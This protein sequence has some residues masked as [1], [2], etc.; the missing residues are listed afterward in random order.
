MAAPVKFADF[1]SLVGDTLATRQ[2]AVLSD[3]SL[4][5][6]AYDVTNAS[7]KIYHTSDRVTFTLVVTI[8]GIASSVFSIA[9]ESG[10]HFQVVY[11]TAAYTNL[12]W[13]RYTKGVGYTWTASAAETAMTHAA[14]DVVMSA[15]LDVMVNA[16]SC[17][18]C[19]RADIGGAPGYQFV[20]AKGRGSNGTWGA[21]VYVTSH[22]GVVG[23]G[24]DTAF[25]SAD[26]GGASGGAQRVLHGA[27]HFTESATQLY[28]AVGSWNVTTGAFVSGTYYYNPYVWTGITNANAHRALSF[29]RTANNWYLCS[30][31]QP[32]G[33]NIT[34]SVVQITWNGSGL[35]VYKPPTT[36]AP[37]GSS[38]YYRPSMVVLSDSKVVFFT[39][40]TTGG[41][42]ATVLDMTTWTWSPSF[43][44]SNTAVVMEYIYAGAQLNVGAKADVV[45]HD[46]SSG[47]FYAD[48]NQTPVAP[49]EATV[50]PAS[51]ATV[52]TDLPTVGV[53]LPAQQAVGFAKRATW[54][55]AND[56]GF[57]TNVKTITEPLSDV[58]TIDGHTE[59][60]TAANELNQGTKYIRAATL[61]PFGQQSAW[62]ASHSFTV[63]HPPAADNLVPNNSEGLDYGLAGE[64]SLDWTFSDTS[65]TD[66]Q[67][68]FQV[69]VENN[70]TGAGVVDSGKVV[71]GDSETI[72]TVPLVSKDVLLRWK[73]RLWDSDDVAGDYSDYATFV[74]GD[75]P[76][77]V[78]TTPAEAG[79]VN[80][81]T[82][83]IEWTFNASAGRVQ[84]QYRVR[85]YENTPQEV[86]VYSSG[87][88]MGA[89]VSHQVPSPVLINTGSYAVEVTVQDSWELQNEDTNLFTT[90][91]VPPA[92]PEFDVN[93]ITYETDG[94][95]SVTWTDDEEDPDF[96]AYR[97][98]RRLS[99]EASWTLLFETTDGGNATYDYHDWTAKSDMEYEFAVVQVANRFGVAV[100]SEYEPETATPISYDYW[101]IH[102][103]DESL[104]IKLDNVTEESF[105]EE[106]EEET[107]QL[108]GRGRRREYGTRWGFSG[109]LSAQVWDTPNRTA[110]EARL[111]LE[112]LKAERREV[113]LRNPFGD[114][115]LVAMG[116]AQ[117]GRM[118]GVGRREFHTLGLSYVEVS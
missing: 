60:L 27:A 62:S 45:M 112:T 49:L 24:H 66:I 57:T 108:I 1:A 2:T 15:D 104:N 59:T 83:L 102:P 18:I 67:T 48:Y 77:V 3:G 23:T 51:G 30:A 93:I 115:W 38:T 96:V 92:V 107:L 53:T 76:T 25:V 56:S 14:G 110:R 100:E 97:V 34:L 75:K 8:T 46:S 13:R 28:S 44:F 42:Y 39:R 117:I 21:E 32:S 12:I 95:V 69:I 74:V 31:Y 90:L 9:V 118:A 40:R 19:W 29:R 16:G 63:L 5:V 17:V 41:V 20:L 109:S 72:V 35:T 86:E 4:L 94:Y 47:D 81:P 103:T 73:V 111:E 84:T 80:N 85:I 71:D 26:A 88:L 54:Q 37:H 50:T 87:W 22:Q 114:L 68:A 106:Y 65:P 101:L 55:I 7:W 78:V 70:E 52:Q 58:N 61:D 6:A 89:A 10:N 116:N 91:W 36:T 64:V 113:Y 82:P 99:V 43:Q 105:T 11:Q 98:Y 79:V 33:G